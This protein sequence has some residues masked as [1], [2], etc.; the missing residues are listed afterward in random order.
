M[1]TT[2]VRYW[3]RRTP[4]RW[5]NPT[6]GTTGHTGNRGPLVTRNRSVGMYP[7]V[8]RTSSLRHNC[9]RWSQSRPDSPVVRKTHISQCV[10]Y[11]SHAF[12]LHTN[13]QQRK[14]TRPATTTTTATEMP[15]MAPVE[16]PLLLVPEDTHLPPSRLY[17][18]LHW[19]HLLISLQ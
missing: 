5:N 13:H 4:S 18:S 16:R 15:A 7:H 3:K 17:P 19:P 10:Y 2:R 1:T 11:L 9:C 14:P 12:P 8:G 6:H